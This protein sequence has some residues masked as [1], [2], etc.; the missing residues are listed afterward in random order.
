MNFKKILGFTAA[1]VM[2]SGILSGCKKAE[3]NPTP[4]TTTEPT[5]TEPAETTPA[6][7]SGPLADYTLLWSD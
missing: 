3:N 7:P 2:L 5:V 6:E 4:E 1:V